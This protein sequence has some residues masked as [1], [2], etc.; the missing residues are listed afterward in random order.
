M[1]FVL[2]FDE[3]ALEAMASELE[4]TQRDIERAIAVAASRTARWARSQIA[5]GLASRLGVSQAVLSG[6]RLTAKSGRSSARVWVAL[7]PLNL[8]SAG[9][10]ATARGLRAGRQSMDGAFLMKGRYGKAAMRRQGRKRKPLEAASID[11]LN[12]GTPAINQAWPALNERFLAFYAEE[13]ERRS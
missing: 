1:P 7:N 13:L 11:V 10:T 4:L 8:A 6:K 5:R 9:A 3:A 2:E 12:E